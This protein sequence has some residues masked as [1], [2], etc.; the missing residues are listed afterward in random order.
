MTV[1]DLA[2]VL[3][4]ILVADIT[5]VGKGAEADADKFVIEGI[6]FAQRGNVEGMPK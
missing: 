6:E 4:Y 5:E 1:D 2:N 3:R